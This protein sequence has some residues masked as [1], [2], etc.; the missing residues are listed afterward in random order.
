MTQEVHLDDVFGVARDL[1]LNYV[2]RD[3]VDG[4]LVEA[5][6]RDEHIVIYGSSKQGKT[7]LR[8]HTLQESDYLVV[9]CSNKWNLAHL[10]SAILK[11]AGYVVEGTTTR[12]VSGQA[13]IAARLKGK[14]GLFGQGVEAEG[15][16][17]ASVAK[18][19]AV[20]SQPIELDPADVN[21]IV[22]ALQKARA[23]SHGTPADRSTPRDRQR[24]A[25]PQGL[26]S[27]TPTHR[28]T[29]QLSDGAREVG[30]PG[31]LH[32]GFAFLRP[33]RGVHR[34]RPDP[35]VGERGHAVTLARGRS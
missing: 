28:S 3:S 30:E 15:A 24:A 20:D 21:D 32:Q 6:A 26:L 14:M 16:T 17:E 10:H 22:D 35:G 25:L 7:C 31:Q 33:T 1:P 12:T 23:W 4:A 27:F 9:T 29:A 34:G 13:K 2:V 5:L 18:D 11:A 19:K 8:K